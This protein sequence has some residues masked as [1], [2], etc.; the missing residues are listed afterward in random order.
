MVKRFTAPKP[1]NT[2]T[3]NLSRLHITITPCPALYFEA[4]KSCI[5]A[6]DLDDRELKREEFLIALHNT[7]LLGFGRVREHADCSEMCSLGIIPSTRSKGIGK[8]LV[9]ALMHKAKQQLFLVC[10]IP[11]YFK[12]FGFDVTTD[13]PAAIKNK[14]DYCNESLPVDELYVVLRQAQQPR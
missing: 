10:V 6:F 5:R 14:M 13:Y 9:A 1:H 8:Q 12:P 4:V 11:N 2:S 7:E 3:D